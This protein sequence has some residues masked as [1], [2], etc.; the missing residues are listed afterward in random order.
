MKKKKVECMD[1]VIHIIFILACVTF[2]V[3]LMMVISASFSDEQLLLSEGVSIL[4][5][6]FTLKAYES[7][8]RN[9]EQMIR[10]YGVTIFQSVVGTV[11]SILVAAMIAYPMSRSNFKYRKQVTWYVLFTMLLAPSM[12]PKYII[13]SKYYH[14]TNSM[15]MYIL[16]GIAGGA[17]NTLVLRTFFMG[18]SESLFESARIEGAS[19][20]KIFMRIALP[21]SKPALASV[22]F[23]TLVSKWNDYT[24]SM[25]YIRDEKYYTLQYLLQRLNSEATYLKGVAQRLLDMGVSLDMAQLNSLPSETLKFAMCVIAAGPMLVAFPFFQKYFEKGLTIGAVKG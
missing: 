2:I 7:A 25:V 20:M 6:G 15:W 11:S 9:G 21:L 22:G 4:P 24:V 14:I 5:K 10:A 19:E 17:W 8:F 13:Y 18:I 23:L 12:I 1:I 3:P 16:P